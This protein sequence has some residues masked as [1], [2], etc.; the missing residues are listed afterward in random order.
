MRMGTKELGMDHDE[1]NAIG[2]INGAIDAGRVVSANDLR[3][4]Y[5]DLAR[6]SPMMQATLRPYV[7]KIRIAEGDEL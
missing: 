4:V 7:A 6:L 3:N 2:R 5:A 1:A